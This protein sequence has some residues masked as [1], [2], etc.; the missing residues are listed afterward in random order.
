MLPYDSLL[1]R[2]NRAV[3]N[4]W[5]PESL[6]ES[7]HYIFWYQI[8]LLSSFPLNP[9]TFGIY[10]VYSLFLCFFLFYI[11]PCPSQYI[12]PCICKVIRT[13]GDLNMMIMIRNRNDAIIT[14]KTMGFLYQQFFILYNSQLSSMKLFIQYVRC[15]WFCL[16]IDFNCRSSKK[17]SARC[18]RDTTVIS[19]TRSLLITYLAFFS[20][21][22]TPSFYFIHNAVW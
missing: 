8:P 9:N 12:Y 10:N 14:T 5:I 15:N 7:K 21:K 4:L 13:T 16:P 2:W 19:M 18:A 3:V 22:A 17:F 1:L 6:M 20:F 11:I